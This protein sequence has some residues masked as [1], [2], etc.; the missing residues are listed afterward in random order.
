MVPPEQKEEKLPVAEEEEVE[1]NV[2][3]ALEEEWNVDADEERKEDV[4]YVEEEDDERAARGGRTVPLV[5][6]CRSG[7]PNLRGGA[8]DAALGRTVGPPGRGGKGKVMGWRPFD[9]T[10]GAV[11]TV[12]RGGAAKVLVVAF[13]IDKHGAPHTGTST[14]D[15]AEEWTAGDGLDTSYK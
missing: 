1:R 4:Q 13:D 8:A 11:R 12:G 14:W 5:I 7:L 15:G 3:A 6:S 2:E 9:T 10:A